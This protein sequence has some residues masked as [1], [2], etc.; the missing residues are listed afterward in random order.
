MTDSLAIGIDLGATK[1]AAALITNTGEV[2]AAE[3]IGTKAS[4]GFEAVIDRVAESIERVREGATKPI[5]GIGIGTPGQ[6]DLKNGVVRGA[7]NL[8]WQS[9]PLSASVRARLKHDTPIWIQKDTNAGALGEYF[10]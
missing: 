8:G 10:F 2:L 6:V 9:V 7:V 5:T 3:Q 4:D 1:I